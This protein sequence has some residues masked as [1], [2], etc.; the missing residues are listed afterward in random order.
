LRLGGLREMYGQEM[1]ARRRATRPRWHRSTVL[2]RA[3]SRIGVAHCE[4]VGVVAPSGRPDRTAPIG[5]S[6]RVAGGRGRRCGGGGRGF[7]RSWPGRCCGVAAAPPGRRDG[8]CSAGRVGH[9]GHLDTA[10]R[11][12]DAGVGHVGVERGRILAVSVSD[13]VLGLTRSTTIIDT[14]NSPKSPGPRV[15]SLTPQR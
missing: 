3:S 13:Q 5:C 15:R 1:A 8:G 12:L 6:R 14:D 10:E 7:R 9:V 11:D 2:G 4:G